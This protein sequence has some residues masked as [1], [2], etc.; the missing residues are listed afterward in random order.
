MGRRLTSAHTHVSAMRTHWFAHLDIS[1]VRTCSALVASSQAHL[2]K[3]EDDLRRATMDHF[4]SKKELYAELPQVRTENGD[5]SREGQPIPKPKTYHASCLRNLS[6]YFSQPNNSNKR[7]STLPNI[8]TTLA[9]LALEKLTYPKLGDLVGAKKR[10][11]AT[12]P[13]SPS[14]PRSV[15][16]RA[17]DEPHS[18]DRDKPCNAPPRELEGVCPGLK[19]A[20]IKKYGNC[21]RAWTNGFKQRSIHSKCKFKDF[22]LCILEL[23][24]THPEFSPDQ[25]ADLSE[26]FRSFDEDNEGTITLDELDK[27]TFTEFNALKNFALKKFKTISACFRNLDV[28]AGNDGVL[29]KKEFVTG[30]LKHEF[31]GNLNFLF[32][33]LDQDGKGAISEEEFFVLE[34]NFFVAM[35]ALKEETKE[36]IAAKLNMKRQRDRL[37][38]QFSARIQF[39][40]HAERRYGNIV[41]CFRQMDVNGD[42][43]ISRDEFFKF[44]SAS[45]FEGCARSAWLAFD[46]ENCGIT[47]LEHIDMSACRLLT[48]F[49]D[50]VRDN[51]SSWEEFLAAM[52]PK[53]KE[54]EFARLLTKWDFCWDSRK[55]YHCLTPGS[56][57]LRH[58]DMSFLKNWNV[59]RWLGAYPNEDAVKRF[60]KYLDKIGNGCTLLA[61]KKIDKHG[62]NCLS[63]KN[64]CTATFPTVSKDDLA[65]M[66]VTL[67][68]GIHTY[69]AYNRIDPDEAFLIES[70]IRWA[71]KHFGGTSAAIRV[72]LC[73][74]EKSESKGS[75]RGKQRAELEESLTLEEFRHALDFYD[76]PGNTTLLSHII[77]SKKQAITPKYLAFLDGWHLPDINTEEAKKRA[78]QKW[79]KVRVWKMFRQKSVKEEEKELYPAMWCTRSVKEE[80][81]RSMTQ[82]SAHFMST[83]NMSNIST[84]P[85]LF[86]DERWPSFSRST[87]EWSM[88]RSVTDQFLQE[89]MYN[90]PI[91]DT[92]PCKTTLSWY[93]KSS[94]IAKTG[95]EKKRPHTVAHD[96][97]F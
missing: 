33:G 82:D 60:R 94:P 47:T 86:T 57:Y 10:M 35:T 74:K 41:K 59:A 79:K 67:N 4:S 12:P 21:L 39:L 64:L 73:G 48:Q 69:L 18:S 71:R 62:A 63:W 81:L 31:V 77:T 91:R 6:L 90:I 54:V 25:N 1:N 24:E 84:A 83:S 52:P 61:W 46:R 17:T 20:L 30:L 55:L 2:S 9:P 92:F 14:T 11:S 43:S 89:K 15:D 93:P 50:F 26:M 7:R 22:V 53:I 23:S 56:G 58:D 36:Q 85:S 66:W 29:T 88:N 78:M 34:R 19:V 32:D 8:R 16:T 42:N 95:A 13:S 75:K 96:V 68:A 37:H 49:R 5:D 45:G 3:C 70:F 72:F 28:D 44:C 65:A 27:K 38:A 97:V 80:A 40:K 76:F 87:S 51:F